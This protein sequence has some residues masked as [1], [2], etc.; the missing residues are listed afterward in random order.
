MSLG[1]GGDYEALRG[2]SSPGQTDK[3]DLDCLPADTIPVLLRTRSPFASLVLRHGRR[4]VKW[5]AYEKLFG[6]APHKKI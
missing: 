6:G 3:R 4:P 2:T 5:L 1:T